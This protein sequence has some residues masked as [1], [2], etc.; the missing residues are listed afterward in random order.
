[1]TTFGEHLRERTVEALAGFPPAGG[2]GTYA[3]TFR[4]DSVDQDP[5]FPYLALGYVTE[6]AAHV[7]DG[8]GPE[9]RWEARWSY[10]YFPP[11]GLE[12]IRVLGHDP[13][14]DPRGTELYRREVEEAEAQA[15]GTEGLEGVEGLWDEDEPAGDS[16]CSGDVYD[17]WDE[18]AERLRSE[19]RDLCVGLARHLHDGGHLTAALG[20]AVP[21]ILYDMFDPEDMFAMTRA[22]NPAALITDF[23]SGEVRDAP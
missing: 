18:R 3:V 11:S 22:A 17:A 8:A 2:E 1:M 12:G 5:R 15:G 10:A 19:F 23:L 6:G 20:R 7:T 14:A 21:V 16:R 9:D 13:D 4:L